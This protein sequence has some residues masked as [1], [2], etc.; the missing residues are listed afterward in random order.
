MRRHTYCKIQVLPHVPFAPFL[1][2]MASILLLYK[3]RI[4]INTCLA[5]S[6]CQV[7]DVENIKATRA[8]P[9]SANAGCPSLQQGFCID[10]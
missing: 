6:I 4:I 10:S 1:N 3:I 2:L 9:G 7:N 8:V 5:K